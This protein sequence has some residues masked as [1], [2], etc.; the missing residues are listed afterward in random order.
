ML[1][2]G[3]FDEIYLSIRNTS[4]HSKYHNAG[5]S[6]SSEKYSEKSVAVKHRDHLL[7]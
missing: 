4:I 1:Y 5:E 3:L 2:N 7:V 6:E